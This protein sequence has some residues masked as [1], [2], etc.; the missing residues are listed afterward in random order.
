[1]L[2]S[3]NRNFVKKAVGGVMSL[4]TGTADLVPMR[5]VPAVSCDTAVPFSIKLNQ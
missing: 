5:N 4:E 2:S 3:S 1:M